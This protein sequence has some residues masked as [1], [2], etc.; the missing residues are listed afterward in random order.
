MTLKSTK[1][2]IK[3]YLGNLRDIIFFFSE[4]DNDFFS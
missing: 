3:E 1:V 4:C 2:D